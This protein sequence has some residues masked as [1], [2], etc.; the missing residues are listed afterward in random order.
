MSKAQTSEPRKTEPF[1]RLLSERLDRLNQRCG[2]TDPE[3]HVGTERLFIHLAFDRIHKNEY[4][5]CVKRGGNIGDEDAR[6]LIIQG[7]AGSGKTSTALHRIAFLLYRFKETL[8]SKDILIISPNRVF[9]DYISNVLP[10]LGEES[11][12]EIGMERLADELLEQR[13]S[14]FRAQQPGD[15]LQNPKTGGKNRRRPDQGRDRGA[16]PRCFKRGLRRRH[17]RLLGAPGQGL[18]I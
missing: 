3:S 13:L 8:S 11:V 17:Q 15:R 10:E 5:D 7:V 14:C 12:A 18:G 2:S 6:T 16:P 9:A 1:E 4:W